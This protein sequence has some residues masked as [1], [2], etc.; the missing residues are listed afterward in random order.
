VLLN[1]Y[2]GW[3]TPGVTNSSSFYEDWIQL[4]VEHPHHRFI[5]SVVT[6][7]S[8]KK[9]C[10]AA[11]NGFDTMPN[12]TPRC[13]AAC[14]D[15]AASDSNS[16]KAYR[17]ENRLASVQIKP[18]SSPRHAEFLCLIY[19]SDDVASPYLPP[20]LT[21]R[22]RRYSAITLRLGGAFEFFWLPPSSCV[23]NN[24]TLQQA[25]AHPCSSGRNRGH[26]LPPSLPHKFLVLAN[27][28]RIH[29]N[30]NKIKPISSCYATYSGAANDSG[31]SKVH[32]R[33]SCLATA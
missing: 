24:E 31:S 10:G 3:V 27:S 21:P 22:A 30:A 11:S 12:A 7:C 4:R 15:G 23:A 33:E 1:F 14:A 2:K 8:A 32:R 17:R 19:L 16:P 13:C 29:L 6:A 28:G 5:A 9:R 26:P 18:I 25:S 20:H